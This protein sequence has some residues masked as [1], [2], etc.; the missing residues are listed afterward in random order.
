M[1]NTP[2]DEDEEKFSNSEYTKVV[3]KA[4]KEAISENDKV[5]YFTAGQSSFF[6]FKFVLLRSIVLNASRWVSI[7]SYF[8]KPYKI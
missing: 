5:I 8:K 4:L 6:C 3:L 7:A 2:M 1:K